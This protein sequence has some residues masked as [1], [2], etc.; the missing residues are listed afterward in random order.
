[1]RRRTPSRLLPE[2][3]RLK[4]RSLSLTLPTFLVPFLPLTHYSP[5]DIRSFLFSVVPKQHTTFTFSIPLP[6]QPTPSSLP[7]T[8]SSPSQQPSPSTSKSASP[9]PS[10]SRRQSPAPPLPTLAPLKG[11]E[12]RKRMQFELYGSQFLFRNSDRAGR[13]FK[14]KPGTEIWGGL[15]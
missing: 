7:P 6:L 13:K 1:M 9:F 4:V 5:L 8:P 10:S 2:Q 12:G 11:G 3:T 15:G 14:S